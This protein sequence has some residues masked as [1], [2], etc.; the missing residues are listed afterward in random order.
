MSILMTRYALKLLGWTLET[1]N[2]I[3]I[4]TLLTSLLVLVNIL[5]IKALLVRTLPGT[6]IILVT[7]WFRFHKGFFLLVL[8]YWEVHMLMSHQIDLS[9]LGSLAICLMCLAVAF[10]VSI[11]F[12]SCL[13]MLAGNLPRSMLLSLIVLETNSSSFKKNQKMSLWR[14]WLFLGDT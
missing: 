12:A 10:E 7:G 6:C 11:F 13:T 3:W 9:C 8:A 1:F 2:V 4:F 5:G 14:I